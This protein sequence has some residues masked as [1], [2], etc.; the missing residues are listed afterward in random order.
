MTGTG[1]AAAVAA[2]SAALGAD[3]G[4]GDLWSELATAL[5][6]AGRAREAWDAA[7]R[8][9]ELAPRSAASHR[10]IGTVAAALGDPRQAES[11]YRHAL[12]LDPTDHTTRTALARL[13]TTPTPPPA[14]DPRHTPVPTNALLATPSDPGGALPTTGRR[15]APDPA[16]PG[17]VVSTG[18]R[19]RAPDP[20]ES[21][22]AGG[23]RRAADFA[24]VADG[25]W[26]D[27]VPAPG[28]GGSRHAADEEATG[29][30][31]GAEEPVSGRRRAR[32]TAAGLPAWLGP[33]GSSR[34]DPT[35]PPPW[36]PTAV[37]RPSPSSVG[38][39]APGPAGWHAA[40]PQG[41]PP[42]TEPGPGRRPGP[43]PAAA[44][45]GWPAAMAAPGAV[46]VG[47]TRV[48]D[49]GGW[50][51]GL[52]T[53]VRVEWLVGVACFL[54][55]AYGRL[56]PYTAGLLAGALVVAGA[57]GRLRWQAAHTRRPPDP[58]RLPTYAAAAAVLTAVAVVPAAM[59]GAL[60]V[61]RLATVAAVTCA[62]VAA[63]LLGRTAA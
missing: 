17:D 62:T 9:V 27:R 37:D 52:I 1:P 56:A 63:V 6:A 46:P 7:A 42:A 34:P 23:R 14:P 18:G 51:R 13:P 16:D 47:A 21:R 44:T 43:D 3:P 60:D 33:R 53:V 28:G 30:R 11:A 29:A 12:L 35:A 58:D 19:R 5:V 38:A 59:A 45:G 20:D 36:P 54:G 49:P 24:D 10:A 31:H 50:R 61:A 40:E 15:R 41:A 2:L 26:A 55:L 8:A 25:R 57:Y 32:D 22:S 4:R 39:P 48:V